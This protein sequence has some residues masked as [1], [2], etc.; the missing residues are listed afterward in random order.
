MHGSCITTPGCEG[1][2]ALLHKHA[3][4]GIG[5]QPHGELASS[6]SHDVLPYGDT[7]FALLLA[8]FLLVKS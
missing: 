1:L 6:A 8:L 7:T 4:L 3:C 2:S 5:L